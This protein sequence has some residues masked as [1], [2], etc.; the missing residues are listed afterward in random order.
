[1][2]VKCGGC[3]VFEFDFVSDFIECDNG[4][5]FYKSSDY[6]TCNHFHEASDITI[7][8]FLKLYLEAKKN[9]DLFL[10]LT[11]NENN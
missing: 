6:S 4:I 10:D 1:M 7:D 5:R 11:K 3:A 2:L 9:N 8:E